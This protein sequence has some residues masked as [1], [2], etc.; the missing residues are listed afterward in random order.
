[1]R[2]KID[3]KKRSVSETRPLVFDS[4]SRIEACLEDL[5][6]AEN[7]EEL[8][9]EHCKTLDLGTTTLIMESILPMKSLA[10]KKSIKIKMGDN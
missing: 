9:F 1:M 8:V 3:D 6:R 5:G 4:H 7:L 10:H 2:D